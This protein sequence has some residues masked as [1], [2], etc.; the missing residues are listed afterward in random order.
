MQFLALRKD[1]L[2]PGPQEPLELPTPGRQRL[3]GTTGAESGTHTHPFENLVKAVAPGRST[4]TASYATE[5]CESQ[6][7]PH[8]VRTWT[9]AKVVI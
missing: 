8:L 3:V 9:P 5:A 7:S 6:A 4:S 1:R 2:I